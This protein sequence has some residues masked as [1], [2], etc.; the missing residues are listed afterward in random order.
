MSIIVDEIK[1]EFINSV[2]V[3]EGIYLLYCDDLNIV[4]RIFGTLSRF[5]VSFYISTR[6]TFTEYSIYFSVTSILGDVRKLAIHVNSLEMKEKELNVE[7]NPTLK[8]CVSLI[9]SGSQKKIYP[10]ITITSGISYN[11]FGMLDSVIKLTT[12]GN[13]DELM[14]LGSWKEI[15]IILG[16]NSVLF[17]REE[18]GYY[19]VDCVRTRNINFL[20]KTRYRKGYALY[21]NAIYFVVVDSSGT[22]STADYCVVRDG[23]ILSRRAHIVSKRLL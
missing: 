1:H 18:G 3:D 23:V 13:V 8:N 20:S 14:K 2:N 7:W 19:S 22:Y 10:E 11:I 15:P 12:Y 6:F 5:D 16:S 17:N 9:Y 4:L 21:Q